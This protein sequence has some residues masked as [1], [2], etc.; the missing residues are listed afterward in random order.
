MPWQQPFRTTRVQHIL[1]C[2]LIATSHIRMILD[3]PTALDAAP[4]AA[5]GVAEPEYMWFRCGCATVK[6]PSE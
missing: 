3:A 6:Y 5:R 2:G 1:R 4:F